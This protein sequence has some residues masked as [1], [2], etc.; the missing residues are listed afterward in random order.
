MLKDVALVLSSG[1]ARG[2]A[3]IGVIEELVQSGYRITSIAGTSMGSVIG[4]MYALGK[5]EEYKQWLLQ[6]TKMD[7]IKFLDSEHK[8]VY[9]TDFEDD[10]TGEFRMHDIIFNS[11]NLDAYKRK[12]E[13]YLKEYQQKI[14][15]PVT[16]AIAGANGN[17]GS[18]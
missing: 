9:F 18:D 12:V 10:F 7:I 6:V 3:H 16:I 15:G 13:Q 11:N 8:P 17:I 14:P 4:G 5:L 2:I 1:G